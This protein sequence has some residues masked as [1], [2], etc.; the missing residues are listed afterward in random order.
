MLFVYEYGVGQHS[1]ENRHPASNTILDLILTSNNGIP[2]LRTSSGLPTT[3]D[4]TKTNA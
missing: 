2:M 3:S 1:N 4:C